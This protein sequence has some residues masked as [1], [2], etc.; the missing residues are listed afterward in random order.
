MTDVYLPAQRRNIVEGAAIVIAISGVSLV[1]SL[2]TGNR[3]YITNGIVGASS[4]S[5]FFM[6]M[7]FVNSKKVTISK[8]IIEIERIF[9]HTKSTFSS[10]D[11]KVVEMRA[12]FGGGSLLIIKGNRTYRIS[13][14]H[15][16]HYEALKD[17][18]MS[19]SS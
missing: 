18:L 16:T 3:G 10:K 13:T 2:Y 14:N 5:A 7:H 1:A 19:L 17:K 15:I 12:L 8:D 6:A 4:L 9:T 11:I